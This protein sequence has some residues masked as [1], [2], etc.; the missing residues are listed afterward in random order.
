MAATTSNRNVQS[1]AT[2]A[3]REVESPKKITEDVVDY[4]TAYARENPGYT[5][6]ACIGVGFVLGWK[7][8]PW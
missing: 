5:A 4:L 3:S 7:L 8:K 1:R 6:L 2:R